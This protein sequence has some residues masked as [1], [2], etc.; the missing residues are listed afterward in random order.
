MPRIRDSPMHLPTHTSSMPEPA[1]TDVRTS[2]AECCWLSTSSSRLGRSRLL[3]A[4]PTRVLGG[5]LSRDASPACLKAL[6]P[7]WASVTA[8]NRARAELVP[9]AG[10]KVL[11][12]AALWGLVAPREAGGGCVGSLMARP[13]RAVCLRGVGG[14]VSGEACD[15]E[16]G[17]ALL[18]GQSQRE[19][20]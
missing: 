2:P 1:C 7:V 16:K 9:A 14:G 13:A 10:L 15:R 3:G 20:R 18:G 17:G 4:A 6:A 11:P 8:R 12:A 19:A 5:G